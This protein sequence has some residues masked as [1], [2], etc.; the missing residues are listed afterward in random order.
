MDFIVEDELERLIDMLT[1]NKME[2]DKANNFMIDSDYEDEFSHNEITKYQYIFKDGAEKYLKTNYSGQ[3]AIFVDWCV[4]IVTKQFY[5]EKIKP[6][7]KC[8][9]LC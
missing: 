8:Y 3:Y 6:Y 4:H 5:E 2:S 7:S 1:N 9:C